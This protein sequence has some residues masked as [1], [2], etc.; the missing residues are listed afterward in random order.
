MPVQ[1]MRNLSDLQ[2]KINS[3]DANRLFIVDFFADWCGPCRYI[4]PIFENFSSRFT[5]ATFVKVNVDNSPGLRR[6]CYCYAAFSVI[7]NYSAW[8]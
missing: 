6:S 7:L 2:A 4:A 1:L 3:A 8:V 5:N